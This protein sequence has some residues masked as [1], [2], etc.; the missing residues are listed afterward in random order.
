MRIAP[1]LRKYP[2]HGAPAVPLLRPIPGY[3][4]TIILAISAWSCSG[5]E[6][7]TRTEP[8]T[9]EGRV[10][11]L[12]DQN[13]FEDALELLAEAGTQKEVDVTDDETG[14]DELRVRV[15]LAY[16]NYLTHEADH[17]AMGARM[18]D[19]LRHF[20]RVLELDPGNTQ[21]QSHIELIEGIYE[22]MGRDIPQGVAE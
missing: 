22:Q 7:D 13:E 14:L 12:L 15:H 2:N 10:A 6:S 20:R 8:A 18:G 11:L 17:L 16:A 3:L 21:A 19:A 5:Q 9:M 1:N 4:L